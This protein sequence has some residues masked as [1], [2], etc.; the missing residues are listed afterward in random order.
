VFVLARL[1]EIR[2]S[3]P[4]AYWVVWLGTL[5]NRMGGF[6]MPLLTFYLVE[7]RGLS[8]GAAGV[9]VGL[10]GAGGVVAALV[11]GVLADRL[12]RR[13]TMLLSM[14]G[15]GVLMATLGFARDVWLIALNTFALGVAGELYRPAVM[16]FVGDVVPPAQRLRAFGYLYWIINLSFAAAALAGGLLSRWSYTALF[17]GD[18]ATMFGYAALIAFKLPETR[19]PPVARPAGGRPPVRLLDVMADRTF[20]IYWA[21]SFALAMMFFQSA[22]PLSAHLAAQGFDQGDFG[23]VIAVNGVLIVL[24]QPAVTAWTARFDAARVLAAAALFTGAG[25]ALH[26]VAGVLVMHGVA[27]AVWTVGEIAAAPINSVTVANLAAAEARGRYQGVF[28][29]AFSLASCLGP[30]AGGAVIEAAGAGVLWS[31][32]LGLGVVTAVG[33][34]V[35]AGGRRARGA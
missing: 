4:E 8:I 15:G 19:P 17:V 2:R 24:L 32:C 16:A 34:L 13:A 27:V 30:V 9:I 28:G 11:G 14:I 3:L 7:E 6:V 33:Y 29:M 5:I 31:A 23:M 18:A 35:S 21:L 20:M 12:G 26:G 25:F 22:V 10:F 1:T